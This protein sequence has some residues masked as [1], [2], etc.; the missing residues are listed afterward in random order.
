MVS[1]V[2]GDYRRCQAETPLINL[3][4]FA[5]PALSALYLLIS[6][7]KMTTLFTFCHSLITHINA[8]PSDKIATQSIVPTTLLADMRNYIM[9][10]ATDFPNSSILLEPITALIDKRSNEPTSVRDVL[11]R[12]FDLHLSYVKTAIWAL[13]AVGFLG[14]VIGL[15]LGFASLGVSLHE[16]SVV[17]QDQSM[18]DFLS[19][20]STAFVATF[21]ALIL[22]V[23]L[24]FTVVKFETVVSA[25]SST[26]D[27]AITIAIRRTLPDLTNETQT[28]LILGFTKAAT[29]LTETISTL[30]NNFE[31]NLTGL[32]AAKE[33]ISNQGE[34]VQ[35][36]TADYS[37]R[38]EKL[39]EGITALTDNVRTTQ[40]QQA[41][42]KN[43]LKLLMEA[44]ETIISSHLTAHTEILNVA[45]EKLTAASTDNTKLVASFESLE[46]EFI[47]IKQ[48]IDRQKQAF[49]GPP[50]RT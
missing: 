33:V 3:F 17:T 35:K 32:A 42:D 11:E 24:A 44:I 20:F 18:I 16:N 40:G 50:L 21:W 29:S 26:A 30:I 4:K 7:Y 15:T 43:K 5:E 41:E 36:T 9:G 8:F 37:S 2:R 22:T 48:I 34:A 12:E 27:Q 6:N 19:K 49:L 31:T 10:S 45:M 47:E 28:D 25:A 1:P 46:K 38:L 39:V 14:T 13:P 23:V